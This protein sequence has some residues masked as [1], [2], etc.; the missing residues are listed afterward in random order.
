MT[1]TTV[2]HID[3]KEDMNQLLQKVVNI[4]E[5]ELFKEG[6]VKVEKVEGDLVE[7]RAS[8]VEFITKY[9]NPTNTYAIEYSQFKG[10]FSQA[11]CNEINA[12]VAPQYQISPKKTYICGW[13]DAGSYYNLQPN[14]QVA[15]LDS[16]KAALKP[17]TKT[18]YS[19]R[20]YEGYIS[21]HNQFIMN[22]HQLA[23][24]YEDVKKPTIVLNI[25]YP[26]WDS[27]G[28]YELNFAVLTE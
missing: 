13:R 11:F 12:Y 7:T 19:I 23:I 14:Q 26:F 20:G 15:I 3:T 16:P 18:G 22:S 27:P 28:A 21:T 2:Y 5:Q 9:V 8:G 4:R 6:F 17:S 24:A 1:D 25:R 10:K